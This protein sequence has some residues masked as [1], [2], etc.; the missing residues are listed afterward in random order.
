MTTSPPED[1]APS[2]DSAVERLIALFDRWPEDPSTWSN[3]FLNAWARTAFRIQYAGNEPYRRYCNA[4]DIAPED[5]ASWCDVPPVPTAATKA[6]ISFSPIGVESV[7]E[8]VLITMK[9]ASNRWSSI[10]AR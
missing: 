6:S 2:L 3:D 5:V 10:R 7:A 4:R 1:P 8:R 9:P